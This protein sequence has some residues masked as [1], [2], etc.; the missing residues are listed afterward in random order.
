MKSMMSDDKALRFARLLRQ[1]CGERGC[2]DCIFWQESC[3]C[4]GLAFSRS[5]QHWQLNE[6]PKPERGEKH[7][8]H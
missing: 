8:N 5:P 6:P 2:I 7:E 3:L 4:C 1:Y